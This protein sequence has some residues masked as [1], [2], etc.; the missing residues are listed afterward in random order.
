L[1]INFLSDAQKRIQELQIS[2]ADTIN[3]LEKT[4]NML[5]LQHKINIDYQTEVKQR[6]VVMVLNLGVAV[7]TLSISTLH[8][9]AA[10]LLEARRTRELLA[11]LT[12]AQQ[13]ALVCG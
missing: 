7:V 5:V 11:E 1:D 10:K 8:G 2:H 13:V 9:Q 4:R 3:E 6:L 12:A